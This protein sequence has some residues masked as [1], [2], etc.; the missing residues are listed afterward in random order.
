[1]SF[2][3]VIATVFMQQ[4]RWKTWLLAS[5]V[6]ECWERLCLWG[7]EFANANLAL[8]PRA[9]KPHTLEP[10]FAHPQSPMAA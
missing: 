7:M 4:T 6:N 1:M 10:I 3:S 2:S 9:S 8:T 5:S